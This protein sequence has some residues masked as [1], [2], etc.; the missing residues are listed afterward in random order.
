MH[1]R[2]KPLPAWEKRI[3]WFLAE[4]GRRVPFQWETRSG[5]W[6][7]ARCGDVVDAV[8]KPV[9]FCRECEGPIKAL[10]EVKS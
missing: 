5:R 1:F 3:L 2:A 9:P 8:T 6:R 4:K 7:C 10:I